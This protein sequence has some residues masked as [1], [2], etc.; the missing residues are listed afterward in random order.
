MTTAITALSGEYLDTRTFRY[1]R[2]QRDAGIEYQPWEERLKP[3][4]PLSV[5]I[6]IA[7]AAVIAG[8]ATFVFA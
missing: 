2:T 6:A 5:D 3:L 1:A 4:R 8:V 7:A